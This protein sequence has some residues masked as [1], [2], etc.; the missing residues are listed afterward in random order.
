MWKR[1]SPCD[2]IDA[3][4]PAWPIPASNSRTDSLRDNTNFVID[5][6]TD[7]V[8]SRYLRPSQIHSCRDFRRNHFTTSHYDYSHSC[9]LCPDHICSCRERPLDVV[10]HNI[11][12][13][14]PSTDHIRSN[15]SHSGYGFPSDTIDKDSSES[16][17]DCLSCRCNDLVTFG[18]SSTLPL[19]HRE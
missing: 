11:T 5:D 2:C 14:D 6:D 9:Y 16:I 19:L 10:A 15:H 17:S 7:Q 3:D 1:Q 18:I 8:T 12:S 4:C 13:N